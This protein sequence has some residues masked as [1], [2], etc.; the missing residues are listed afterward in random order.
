MFSLK[1]FLFLV[2]IPSSFT[3]LLFF[4]WIEPTPPLMP[5]HLCKKW[6][7][8]RGQ[9]GRKQIPSEKKLGN[10]SPPIGVSSYIFA[11]LYKTSPDWKTLFSSALAPRDTESQMQNDYPEEPFHW[12]YPIQT[13]SCNKLC[14]SLCSLGNEMK[15]TSYK[16]IA[17]CLALNHWLVPICL[18]IQFH[19]GLSLYSN[20]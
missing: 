4:I 8:L 9:W 7:W 20:A 1:F 17:M 3:D 16:P 11:L 10:I 15:I 18:G 12:H 6:K 2:S 13:H 5:Y 14:F 19:V